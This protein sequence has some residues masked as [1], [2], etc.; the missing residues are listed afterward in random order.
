M[1]VYLECMNWMRW[2]AVLVGAALMAMGAHGQE[3]EAKTFGTVGRPVEAMETADGQ[4][5]LV[6]VDMGAG[7]M[8]MSGIEVMR[9]EGEKLKKV[10]MQDMGAENAQ[11]IVL[12][13]ETQTLAVGLSNAG[14]AFLPLADA[15]KG[16]AKVQVLGQGEQSGS[17][18]LAVSRDGQFLFVANEYG[19]GGNVGVIAL[20]R[21]AQGMVHPE[22]VAQIP[23]RM[24]TPGVAI[25]ADGTT[26]YAE[27]E[28][29]PPMVAER[30]PGHGVAEL[31]RTGCVQGMGGRERGNG[32]LFVMDAKRAEALTAGSTMEDARRV[33]RA[34]VDAGCS[35][36][37]E[38]VSA[39]GTKVYVTARGDDRVL[40]FD[41][42]RLKSDPAA[43]LVEAIPSGGEAPVGVRLFEG[44]KMLLVAN[45]NRFA[46]G[47]G[48]LAVID[49]SDAGKPV[50]R[51]IMKTGEFPRNISASAD[52]K[53]LYVTVF[54]GDELMVLRQK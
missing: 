41:A 30:L 32:A 39:D 38:A 26:V 36:V 12:I 23:T 27:S 29:V 28:V 48:S 34:V 52:G 45:S 9:W 7:R 18:Y 53:R 15:L 16:K 19:E 46:G 43:A 13:P 42:A 22:T 24:T 8:R 31:E 21:D 25:S 47:N 14:V 10:A 44:G 6:T 33:V 49:L 4:Y 1:W 40:E 11:G 2:S 35:P 17:G 37:R 50:L 51:Q 3:L 20:H 54:G 5:V